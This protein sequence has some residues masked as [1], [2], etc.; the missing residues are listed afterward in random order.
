MK[1]FFTFIFLISTFTFGCSCAQSSINE[2]FN[3]ADAIF[4]GKVI[5]VDKSKYDFSSNPVYTYTFEI[6]KD[7]K[8][9]H[10]KNKSDKFYTTIYTPLSYTGGGCGS[11]FSLNETYLVY[12]YRSEIGTITNICTRTSDLK[13]VEKIEIDSVQLLSNQF[14]KEKKEIVDID[15]YNDYSDHNNELLSEYENEIL[16]LK[17]VHKIYIILICSLA[18]ILIISLFFNFRKRK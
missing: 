11:T 16:K 13:F 2:S 15:I 12:G 10:P 3:K 4:I 1:Y 8:R 9:K 17:S 5:A 18:L 14:F 7:F 6:T